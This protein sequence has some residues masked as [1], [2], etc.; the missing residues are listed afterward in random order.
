[1]RPSS[2]SVRL[3]AHRLK[4]FRSERRGSLIPF[5]DLTDQEK[6]FLI[7]ELTRDVAVRR[8]NV[9]DPTS[10]SE[11]DQLFLQVLNE[12]GVMCPHPGVSVR[13]TQ[14]GYH[15]S[16]CGCDVVSFYRSFS[17]KMEL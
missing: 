1:M 7:D 2:P 15:C 9:S 17:G 12:W 13:M 6:Q 10:E 4:W 3:E 16:T 14:F 11:F 8:L 5:H